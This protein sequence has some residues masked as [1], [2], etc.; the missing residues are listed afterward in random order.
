VRIAPDT[1]ILNVAC[2]PSEH[3]QITGNWDTTTHCGYLSDI[4]ILDFILYFLLLYFDKPS[5]MLILQNFVT[6][7]SKLS[8]TMSLIRM[9]YLRLTFQKISKEG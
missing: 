6:A 8:L 5:I 1:C 4:E 9:V 3:Y 7:K 2:L